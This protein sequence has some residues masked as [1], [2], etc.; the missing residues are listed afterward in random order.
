MKASVKAGYDT[1]R[2]PLKDILPINTPFTLFISPSQHCNFKCSFCSHSLPTEEK[3]EKGLNQ[4]N[5]SDELF[6]KIVEQSKK[7][8]SK[9][10]RILLTGLGEPLINKNIAEMVRELKKADISEKLEIFT[11]ASLLT[12]QLSSDL[13][14][15]GLTKLRISIQGT[16]A[17]QY[18]KHCGVNINFDELVDNIR[19][20]YEKSRGKCEVYIKIIEEELKD[21]DDKQKFFDIFGNICDDIFI[22]NL[23]KAQPAMGDYEQKIDTVRTFYGEEAKKRDVCP[24]IFYSLQIDSEGNCFPCPPLSLP[25]YFSIGNIADIPL[26]EIWLGKKHKA[27][28]RSHLSENTSK[29]SLCKECVCYLAFTPSTDNLDGHEKE[30]LKK[31][32]MD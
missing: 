27:L 6:L 12:P 19:F 7:F 18:K 17:Q 3:K 24:Y 15:A 21:E 28:I 13:I 2:Q 26:T 16:D 25:Q 14:D 30:I 5:L 31:M 11:N 20:F 9:Y 29:P 32:E 4:L 23:V 22:E 10:K 1:V 8:P